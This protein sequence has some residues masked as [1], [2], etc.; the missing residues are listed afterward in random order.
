MNDILFLDPG[1][2]FGLTNRTSP[3]IQQNFTLVDQYE[4]AE[5]DLTPFKCIVVHDFADQIYLERHKAKIEA[6]LNDHN[7]VIF[8]GHLVREWLPGCA[9][10]TPQQVNSFKDYEVSVVNEHPIF[11]GVAMDELTFNKGVAGFFA[12]GAHI[13]VPAGAQI[14]LTLPGD[15]PITYIDRHTT[16]GTILAHAGRDLFG[17]R[18]QKK[19]S[20]RI[21]EQLLQWIHDEAKALKDGVQ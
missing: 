17:Q 4:F 19:S 12:R 11:E 1:H 3:F 6:F 14:L 10:F 18:M 15:M 20:D 16:K 7:I 5:M 9:I 2:A 21:S 8:G 13:P